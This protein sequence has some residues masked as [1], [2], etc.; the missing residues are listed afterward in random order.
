M[1]MVMK[2]GGEVMN[3]FEKHFLN[4]QFGRGI[5]Q[6]LRVVIFEGRQLIFCIKFTQKQRIYIKI[7]RA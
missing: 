6:R 5:N 1:R 3:L 4:L 2:S 7:S